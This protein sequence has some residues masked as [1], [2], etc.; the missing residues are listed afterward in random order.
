[1]TSI[2]VSNTYKHRK[3][4]NLIVGSI[5]LYTGFGPRDRN[6]VE[7]EYGRSVYGPEAAEYAIE[8]SKGRWAG[9]GLRKR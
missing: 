2:G 3:T 4:I 5:H 6:Q 9:S 7:K 8:V 1:L